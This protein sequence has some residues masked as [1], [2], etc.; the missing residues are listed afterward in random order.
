MCQTWVARKG[1]QMRLQ[2]LTAFPKMT[3]FVKGSFGNYQVL[4]L[5]H[6][7][8]QMSV[9]YSTEDIT[10]RYSVLDVRGEVQIGG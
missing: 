8:F 5:G 9:T 10:I 7:W 3:D 6:V 4:S 2:G 1:A